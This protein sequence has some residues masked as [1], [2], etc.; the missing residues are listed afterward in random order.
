MGNSTPYG[1]HAIDGGFLAEYENRNGK[2]L[3]QAIRAGSTDKLRK[4]IGK[5]GS[6]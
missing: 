4:A 3:L 5:I 6:L 1:S 2:L